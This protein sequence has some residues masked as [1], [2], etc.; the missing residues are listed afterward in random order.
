MPI[1]EVVDEGLRTDDLVARVTHEPS[2][3]GWTGATVK[4]ASRGMDFSI[5]TVSAVLRIEDDE[6]LEARVAVGSLFE[7]PARLR[8]VESALVGADPSEETIRE[9]LDFV[10]VTGTFL[11]DDEATAGYR[12]RIAGAAV[13]KALLLAARL[14]PDG[15]PG[16]GQARM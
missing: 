6:I 4:L 10:R 14:G 3:T 8:E 5:A 13:R 2:G 7:R 1:T 15:V 11:E 9:L 12:Q 16:V